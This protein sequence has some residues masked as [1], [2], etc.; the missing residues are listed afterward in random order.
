MRFVRIIFVPYKK[1]HKEKAL[2]VSTFVYLNQQY[3]L[4]TQ[5]LQVIFIHSIY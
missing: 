2:V 4:H 3:T 1:C 5:S